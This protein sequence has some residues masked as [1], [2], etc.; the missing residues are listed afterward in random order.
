LNPLSLKQEYDLSK[1]EGL[2]AKI[3]ELESK[4]EDITA[5][6]NVNLDTAIIESEAE[7][8]EL[9]RKGYEC[10]IIAPGKW[11]MRRRVI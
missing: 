8:E 2:Q 11:L 10:Q 9:A 6:N 7:L 3:Q 4:I 5:K 1:I